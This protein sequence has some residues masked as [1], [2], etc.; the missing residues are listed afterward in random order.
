MQSTLAFLA[1]AAICAGVAVVGARATTP[2][3]PHWY[4]RIRKPSW[5]PPRIAFPIVWPILY[6][7]I[8]I[9]GW[10]LWDAPSSDCRVA[11]L[12]AFA[13]QLALNAAWSPVFFAAHRIATGLW[14]IVLLD[15]A[16]IATILLSSYVD[17]WA[18]ILL[19]PYL[20]WTVFATALNAKIC[21]LNSEEA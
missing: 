13:V 18:S 15:V 1:F 19:L 4:A 3:I 16:I 2:E 6:T 9:V 8:A 14:I 20:A 12:L 11:A 5:T 17:P 10:R 7:M 21:I